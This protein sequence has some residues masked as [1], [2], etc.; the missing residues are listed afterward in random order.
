MRGIVSRARSLWHD[1]RRRDAVE[2][3]MSDEFRLHIELR[4]ADL[5][6][7]GLT[8]GEAARRARHEFGMTEVHAQMGRAARGLRGID[9]IRFSWL[10]VKLG[11][12]MLHRYPG[13]TIVGG[14]A[15]AF[16][17]W[18][19][20][21]AF[22]FVTQMVNPRIPLRGSERLV[23]MRLW[24]TETSRPEPRAAF[25]FAT[26]QREL[27]TITDLGAH[28]AIRR[29]LAVGDDYGEPVAL[30]AISARAFQ[31]APSTPLLGRGLV[32]ADERPG[33]P[34][35]LVLGSDLWRS[36]FGADPGVVGKV[37]RLGGVQTT[38]V[39]IMRDGFE[40]P[41]SSQMWIP[42][43]LDSSHA[44]PIT[45]P[46]IR[47]FGRLAAGATLD[48]AQSEVAAL[49]ARLALD[50]PLTHRHLRPQVMRSDRSVISLTTGEAAALLSVNVFLAMLLV[51]VC[52]NV[53]LLMFARAASRE[54]EI[55]VRS[56]LGAGRG[57]IVGQF[58]AEALVLGGGAAVVGLVAAG[59]GLRWWIG[60]IETM[61]GPIP[62]WFTGR[63]APGTIVYAVGLAL[64]STVIMG[65]LPAVKVTRRLADRLRS[66]SA[67]GGG[68]AIGGI[69]TVLI[70]GQ[71]AVT[72]A[73][74]VITVFI[75]R[76]AGQ[77]ESFD[78]GFADREYLSARLVMDPAQGASL[79]DTGADVRAQ[80]GPA[81][82]RLEALLA[83]DPMVSGVTFADLLPRMYHP[84]R[85][86][87]LDEGGAA[88]LHPA[89]P[90][91]R[92]TSANVDPGFFA[93]LGAPILHGRGFHSGDMASDRHV[94]IVNESFVRLVLGGRNP[95]GRHIRYV[96]R[97][98]EQ[99]GLLPE[100]ERGPWYEIVGV[101]KD[102]GMA[103]Y[104]PEDPKYAGFYHPTD[105]AHTYPVRIAVHVRGD[106]AAFVPRLRALVSRA[107]AALGMDDVMPL[108]SV[109]DGELR[110]L[111]FWTQLTSVLCGMALLL[112]LAGIY[113]VMSFTVSRRT[114]E[115][116]IR[117]A[118]GA[119][120]RRLVM[121]VFR[122]PVRQVGLGVLAGTG[123]VS[124]L[125][126]AVF[127]GTLSMAHVGALLGYSAFMFAVCL[128]ACAVPTRR[129]LSIEPTEALK[130][131]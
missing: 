73:F 109:R 130:S 86:V 16:A 5:V 100:A 27:R 20:A 69:W 30:T 55:V 77:L 106:P 125:L 45:G 113:A 4:A 32:D 101:V 124:L 53:A 123:L 96:R 39:G 1:A 25:D 66:A 84:H 60:V 122:R 26:W 87:E 21:S 28:R 9:R 54:T 31:F 115:I 91:Y 41:V 78:V 112:S 82:E 56:A 6:R 126:F 23:A 80:Y 117:M 85:L 7:S 131:E 116:G 37:V 104:G 74:P 88:P 120:R 75:Q 98:E 12:R 107:D 68:L 22:E 38:V 89:W 67:G 105:A 62:F 36:R 119:D 18:V 65:T 63:L 94:V 35:V 34:A 64:L 99:E 40:F 42:L 14:F 70:V 129:A 50:H 58:L 118:L 79:A 33:A 49:G 103:P 92:V 102:L 24:N 46:G 114:R 90:A 17:I 128:L 108:A 121:S 81:V 19:G 29:N 97:E 47:V 93:A 111:D 61:T 76:D 10:D 3:E 15:I 83:Q 13:L 59:A 71:I 110:F 127:R 11:F 2:S 48:D 51:L 57:R 72:V 43:R 95:I 52:G 8:P 44:Q